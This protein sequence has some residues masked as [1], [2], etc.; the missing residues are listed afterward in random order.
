MIDFRDHDLSTLAS[1][2]RAGELSAAELTEGALARIDALNPSLNAFVAVDAEGARAQARAIDERV[3]AGEAVGPLAGIPLGVKDLEDAL[4]FVTTYGSVLHVDDAPAERDSVLVARLRSAGCVIVGKTNTP[5]HGSKATTDN[6]AFGATRN[7]WSLERSPGGSSGGS[8]AAVAAGL[9]PLSTGSDGGGSIRIPSA[10]CGL[11]GFKPS[12]GRV[13]AGGPNPPGWLDLSTKGVMACRI[14]D[15]LAGL[16]PAVGPD[17][18]DL[19]SLPPPEVAWSRA[20]DDLHPPR[21]VAWSP[22]LGY[23]HV[24]REVRAVCE[25]AVAALAAEGTEVVEVGAVF[26]ADPVWPW[27]VMVAACNERTAGHLRGTPDWERLDPDFRLYADL[28]GP[29]VGA[30]DLVRAFD[31]AHVANLRLIEVFHQAPLLLAPTVSGQ[32]PFIGHQGTIDGEETPSWVGLTYPFNLTRSP[33]G[34]VCAGLT[35]DGMPVGLQVV[36][37]QHADVAVLRLL[38]VLE[39][40]LALDPRAPIAA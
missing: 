13:P 3:A 14:R 35:A 16:E 25:Q 34:T 20:L 40:V 29:R 33:A 22:D 17:P 24:D 32:T 39:D 27:A 10:L 21:K 8:A 19:R 28:I 18:S 23:A 9:V 37:P 11:S 30:V 36:G 4:G 15:V 5:E 6:V 12:L 31:A 7:P 26:E 1:Q 2:V 38:A